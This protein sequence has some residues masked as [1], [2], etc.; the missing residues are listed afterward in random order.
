MAKQ[1]KGLNTSGLQALFG[2]A[3]IDAPP[4]SNDF[5]YILI[6]HI[7]P[8]SNQPRVV[9][10]K[11]P[12]EELTASIREHGVL[13][14]LAV[15]PVGEGFYEIIAGERRWRAA[16]MAGLEEVPARIL[17]VDDRTAME[18]SLVENLQR[19]NLNP[20]EEAK[21]YRALGD[22]FGLTQEE[23]ARR[24]GK[25]RPVIANALRLLAMPEELIELVQDGMLPAGSARA[26]LSIRTSHAM[27]AAANEAVAKELSTREVERLARRVL[28]EED[29]GMAHDKGARRTN[30]MDEYEQ[31]L[32]KALGRRV[33]IVS[34]GRNK[35]RFELE[36]YGD[37]DFERLFNGLAS[38]GED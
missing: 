29:D 27:V 37:E 12:L 16:R 9:F 26:L 18:L 1:G 38:L 6:S 25:S 2:D 11:E 30:Y 32:G 31:I 8:R 22:E 10:E 33:K 7:E 15:R 3:A 35:G 19:E 14:P 23:I 5:E 36:Y 21:G 24:M 17:D 4:L 13:S 28:R 34:G 20:I